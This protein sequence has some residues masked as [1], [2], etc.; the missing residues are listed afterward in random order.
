MILVDSLF[1]SDVEKEFEETERRLT[2]LSA[3]LVSLNCQMMI[4]LQAIED[5]SNFYRTCSPPGSWVPSAN[6]QCLP[7]QMEPT[8]DRR[9]R[10]WTSMCR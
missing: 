10:R 6:C 7:D 9:R 3:E 5:K 4:H 8:C 1:F 2:E